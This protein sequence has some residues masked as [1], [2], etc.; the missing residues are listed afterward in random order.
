[1]ENFIFICLLILLENID[2]SILG[3]KV[4]HLVK[5]VI[6]MRF[7]NKAQICI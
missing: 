7:C 4:G 6:Y 1:M 2:L 3:L 5:C